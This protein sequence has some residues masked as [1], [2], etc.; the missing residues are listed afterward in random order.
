[1]KAFSGN[2]NGAPGQSQLIA[3]RAS[4]GISISV[5]SPPKSSMLG[6]LRGHRP[7]GAGRQAKSSDSTYIMIAD[8]HST[9]PIQ[10]IGEW[11]MRRQSRAGAGDFILTPRR[12]AESLA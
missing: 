7:D 5:A 2:S 12:S 1:M 9:T 10:N 8:K 4:L 3:A 11:W 6:R